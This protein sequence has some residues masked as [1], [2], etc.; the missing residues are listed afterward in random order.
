MAYHG[1]DASMKESYAKGGITKLKE[2]LLSEGGGHGTGGL[3]ATN[4]NP[5]KH[6][7]LNDSPS[8]PYAHMMGYEGDG[9]MDGDVSVK[10]RGGTYHFK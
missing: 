6:S 10:H 3:K 4:R 8:G 1:N 9:G 7:G 2:T 5:N